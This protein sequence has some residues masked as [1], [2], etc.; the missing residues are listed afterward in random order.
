MAFS[1]SVTVG[2]SGGHSAAPDVLSALCHADAS[3][4]P[5]AGC[6]KRSQRGSD[7]SNAHVWSQHASPPAM[8]LV[9]IILMLGL[10][11]LM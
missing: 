4:V 5:I 9:R 3:A 11:A 2:R 6:G 10:K 7:Y 1:V 8:V